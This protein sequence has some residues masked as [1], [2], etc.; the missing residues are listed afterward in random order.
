MMNWKNLSSGY[1]F[2]NAGYH[3]Y[4][5]HNID[6]VHKNEFDF[7]FNGFYYR[8]RVIAGLFVFVPSI[9]SRAAFIN[10]IFIQ[11][12]KTRCLSSFLC[13]DKQ[14]RKSEL[15]S[16]SAIIQFLFSQFPAFPAEGAFPVTFC[17]QEIRPDC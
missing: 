4:L 5:I 10:P 9:R 6:F 17:N 11:R 8:C 1:F 7:P 12:I 15:L 16:F 2:N 3:S 14:P 13:Q